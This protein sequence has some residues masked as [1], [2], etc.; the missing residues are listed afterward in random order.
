MAAKFQNRTP[1]VFILDLLLLSPFAVAY[2]L[3]PADNI[4]FDLGIFLGFV[5]LGLFYGPT[6]ST[7]QELVPPRIRATV[8]RFTY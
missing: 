1:D 7:V 5:Q 2:R 4:L 3:V 6:F 8:S